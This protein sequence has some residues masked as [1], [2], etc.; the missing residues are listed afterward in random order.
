MM[1]AALFV[2]L[3]YLLGSL[4]TAQGVA[5][6]SRGVDLL[7]VGSGNV[8]AL[9]AYRQLGPWPG[10]VVLAADAGKGAMVLYLG[11]WLAL[12]EAALYAGAVA[13]VLG[14]NFSPFL[15][16]RGGKGAATV[17]GV[18]AVM[19]WQL[20]AVAVAAGLT[21][22]VATRHVVLTLTVAFV[23]LNVLTIGTGQPPGVVALCLGQSLLV[24][25]T[26]LY[27]QGPEATSALRRRRWAA[28]FRIE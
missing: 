27:R 21:V 15:G 10:A 23:L 22:L 1:A 8:G 4:P 28:F 13:V 25:G 11:R 26:H 24:A 7:R 6:L 18:S 14:H 3:S 19:L 9:N 5:R 17:L 12:P 16:L 2:T 20:T